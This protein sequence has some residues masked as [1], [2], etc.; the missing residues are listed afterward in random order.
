MEESNAPARLGRVYLPD[1]IDGAKVLVTVKTYPLPSGT[2]GEL[3]CTAGVTENGNWIRIYPVPFRELPF[4]RQYKKYEW[5]RLDLVRNTADYRPESYKPARGVDEPIRVEGRLDTSNGWAERKR[6]VTKEVFTSMTELIGRAKGDE[7]RS[8]ATLKPGELVDF[9]AKAAAKDWPKKW[10]DKMAQKGLFEFERTVVRK[11]PYKF[12]YVLTTVGDRS[13]RKMMIE[14]WEIGALYWNALGQAHGDEAEAVR[15]VRTK[16]FDE[17]VA[18]KD[19]FLFVGTTKRFQLKSPNPF[20]VVGVF[21]PPL[22][23][24]GRQLSLL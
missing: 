8:L 1:R 9:V 13:P 10:K 23:K 16:Y 19:I 6:F 20:V 11:I 15:L 7:R 22:P 21:Y 2:Y 5:I 12:Y 24:P 3:V 18:K 4:D 17:F 14:D